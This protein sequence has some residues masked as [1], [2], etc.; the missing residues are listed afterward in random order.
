VRVERRENRGEHPG[1]LLAAEGSRGDVQL[2]HQ[3]IWQSVQDRSLRP[4]PHG[5]MR[6]L[7]SVRS[8]VAI[9]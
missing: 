4:V 8:G 6:E 7:H 5:E 9:L 3:D 2:R 1:A